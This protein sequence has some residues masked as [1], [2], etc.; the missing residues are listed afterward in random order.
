M[1]Y[2]P[3]TWNT[4][5]TITPSALNKIEQ[6]IAEGGGGGGNPMI[7]IK[8]H[9]FGSYSHLFHFA[10]CTE[11]TGE[12]IASYLLLPNGSTDKL[13]SVVIY[14]GNSDFVVY[15]MPIPQNMY[16]VFLKPNTASFTTAVSGDI[17][18]T[19]VTVNYGSTADAYIIT[20][21]CE[22]NITEN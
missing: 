2:T 6:G 13:R 22:I 7:Q 5:D 8:T 14:G 18:Q 20:G 16:L 10:I 17:S 12:Y 21:D 19:T 1:A 4:G 15:D 9:S 11:E 3:T